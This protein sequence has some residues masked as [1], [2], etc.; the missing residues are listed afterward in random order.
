MREASTWC[1]RGETKVAKGFKEGEARLARGLEPIIGF[2]CRRFVLSVLVEYHYICMAFLLSGLETWG[3][4]VRALRPRLP[5]L[6][7]IVAR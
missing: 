5:H 7:A 1:K 3:G 4:G 6:Y 2:K